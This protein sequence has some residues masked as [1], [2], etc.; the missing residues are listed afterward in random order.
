MYYVMQTTETGEAFWAGEFDSSKE[1][2]EWVDKNHENYPESYFDVYKTI[3][4]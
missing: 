1:A 3:I 2:W 4:E